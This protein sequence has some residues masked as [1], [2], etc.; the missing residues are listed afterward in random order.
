MQT[1]SESRAKLEHARDKL[2]AKHIY[3]PDV[4][5]IDVGYSLADDR[6][7]KGLVLRIHVRS[8]WMKS[9]PEQRTDFPKEVDGIPVIVMSGD[10]KLEQD[11]PEA[12]PGLPAEST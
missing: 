10:Y 2:V 12:D 6:E 7:T 8:R 5:F 9:S 3:D 1:D 4:T 11:S